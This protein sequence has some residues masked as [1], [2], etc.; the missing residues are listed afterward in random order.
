MEKNN[1]IEQLTKQYRIQ[2]KINQIKYLKLMHL[3]QN[4][5]VFFSKNQIKKLH[6]KQKRKQNGK[7]GQIKI[8]K[9]K[10]ENTITYFEHIS[11]YNMFTLKLLICSH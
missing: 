4:N 3:N 9:E 5:K 11:T 7:I 6:K 10:E 8:E 1:N 2:I